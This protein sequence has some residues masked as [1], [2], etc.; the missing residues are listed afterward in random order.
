M[1]MRWGLNGG[2]E[3]VFVDGKKW[4]DGWMGREEGVVIV[5]GGFVAEKRD[6]LSLSL[7]V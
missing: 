1:M 7:H 6:Y 2:M 3:E 5:G 4:M